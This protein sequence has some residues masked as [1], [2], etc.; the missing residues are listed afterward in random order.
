[1]SRIFCAIPARI[2]VINRFISGI[3]V[4]IRSH[5]L[6]CHLEPIRLQE[7]SE[8]WVVVVGVEVQQLG[9]KAE[10]FID[11]TIVPCCSLR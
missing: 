7:Q 8:F 10:A 6:V 4:P 9:F 1:M 11:D 2:H 3:R 5:A